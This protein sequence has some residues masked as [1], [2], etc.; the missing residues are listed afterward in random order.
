[1]PWTTADL[2]TSIKLK[3]FTP[4]D[5][6]ILQ[7]TDLLSMATEELLAS[8]VPAI[9][10]VNMAYY[11][12][13]QDTSVVVGTSVYR[14]PSRAVGGRLLA[15]TYIPTSGNERQLTVMPYPAYDVLQ[16]SQN[17]QWVERAYIRNQDVV[18]VPS[19]SETGTLRLTYM[20]RPAVLVDSADTTKCRQIIS[21]SSAGANRDL[22]F[23]AAITTIGS[24]VPA[25]DIIRAKPGFDPVALEAQ[26]TS[27]VTTLVPNDS[28]RFSSEPS[29]W[30]DVAIGDWVAL[31]DTSP[32]PQL[33]PEM[34]AVLAQRTA[35]RVLEAL[36]DRSGMDAAYQTADRWEAL[37]LALIAPRVENNVNPMSN[38]FFPEWW[39]AGAYWMR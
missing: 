11:A 4:I 8:C 13:Q 31:P 33:P 21:K 10:K 16:T 26:P 17:N 18:L 32:I 34:H 36:G 23:A 29:W 7:T 35:A 27:I 22:V 9:A 2:L 38:S 15:V 24:G 19:P 5:A 39:G 6:S 20:L 3:A 30:N 28:F 1:M 12:R 37:Q 14:I 25:I